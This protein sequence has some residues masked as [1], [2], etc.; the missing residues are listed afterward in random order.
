MLLVA[1]VVLNSSAARA[2]PFVSA[3][4][5][6]TV[7][8]TP[9]VSVVPGSTS[10]SLGAA[11]QITFDAG[12]WLSSRVAVGIEVVNPAGVDFQQIVGRATVTETARDVI[13]SGVLRYKVVNG[14]EVIGGASLVSQHLGVGNF[15]D[16]PGVYNG[17][18]V[19]G[20]DFPA[21]VNAHVAV[22]PSLRIQFI[23][24]S[25]SS[26]GEFVFQ[27]SVAVRLSY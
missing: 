19:L 20:A 2:Q 12:W 1:A 25:L 23:N 18:A 14:L 15:Q 6:L 3:G 13:I 27:P 16:D 5:G 24:R 9:A 17:G 21:H 10:D 8:S 7:V 11:F 4:A 22:V 26:V